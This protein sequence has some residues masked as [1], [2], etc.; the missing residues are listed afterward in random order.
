MSV[1]RRDDLAKTKSRAK[2]EVFGRGF[3][4]G[5]VV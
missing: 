4:V 2:E 5:G 1:F 3:G